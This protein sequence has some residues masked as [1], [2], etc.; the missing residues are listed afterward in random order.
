MNQLL[1]HQQQYMKLTIA[2]LK[3]E[4]GQLGLKDVN[5]KLWII[6]HDSLY[7]R[8]IG[9]GICVRNRFGNKKPAKSNKVCQNNQNKS[10]EKT[11]IK[12]DV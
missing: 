8:C 5:Q 12:Y 11:N 9:Q 7:Q 10:N 4:S 2:L 3:K 1:M 6:Q